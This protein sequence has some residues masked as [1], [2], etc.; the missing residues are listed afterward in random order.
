MKYEEK[1]DLHEFSMAY[2][3]D[4]L[5]RVSGVEEG[6]N[7]IHRSTVYTYDDSSRVTKS[8]TENT[9][10][11]YTYDGYGRVSQITTKEGSIQI[12]SDVYS[13]SSG[14]MGTS[15][16]IS[17][18][19][20]D[21]AGY[22]KTYN[23]T[24]D[25]NGNIVSIS[26][27][28]NS[29]TYEYDSANQLI[30]ENNQEGGYTYTW[31]Y[32]NAGNILNRKEYAYTTGTLGT[33]TD[34]IGNLTADENYTYTWKH[35]RE[36]QRISSGIQFWTMTYDAN[37]MRTKRESNSTTYEYVY[38]GS[39]L[40]SMKSH[41]SSTGDRSWF[42]FIYDAGGLPMAVE[43]KGTLYYYVT[44]LQGNVIA[45]INSSGNQVVGYR[46]DA[47]GNV[48][49][50]SG[51]MSTTL[52]KENPLRYRGYVFDRETNL[53]YLESRYYNPKTGRFLNADGYTATGQGFVGNNM[54]A[55]CLNNP[56][57]WMDE[58]G[59]LARPA[60]H[61]EN[62]TANRVE[63]IGIAVVDEILEELADD[64]LNYNVNN[65]SE[66]VVLN[67]NYFSS[68]K[69][70]LVIRTNLERSG[71]YGAL[72]ISRKASERSAPEDEVRHEY[73]H[74]KQLD[75]LGLAK[76]TMCIGVPSMFEWGNDSVY[77]R[78]P[79]EITADIYGGVQ[80]RDYP[81]YETAG[82]EYLENSKKWGLLVWFTID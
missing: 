69:G 31:T 59:D 16:Q 52:G 42:Y 24:Y 11:N 18:H 48:L 66:E 4:E 19:V 37:G 74:T 56:V 14:S 26:D 61:A 50:V 82:F 27:G 71:S 32:N 57:N 20:M 5:N 44:N 51:S 9:S 39:L 10:R 34:T 6:N 76:Y 55:Y 22:D 80:S 67:S 12:K 78:R 36:L 46:Y 75:Q 62:G 73:G 47:W 58:S 25:D 3:Y 1:S 29:I 38:S 15:G 63:D 53:Y 60:R 2:S 33:A 35:G 40:S 68:Y 7:G 81:G 17:Q 41:N 13:Y 49:T 43:Y 8:Q 72:F 70:K 54:Y 45:I 21:T 64:A 65:E 79:W 23:Y 77:Y 28:S 30:R